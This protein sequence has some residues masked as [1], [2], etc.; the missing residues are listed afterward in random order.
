[1]IAYYDG[2]V[3]CN[4]PNIMAIGDTILIPGGTV[5]EIITKTI[6]KSKIPNELYCKTR[7]YD[8]TNECDV[9]NICEE[10][11]QSS[12][13]KTSGPNTND[14]ETNPRLMI[15]LIIASVIISEDTLKRNIERYRNN[16]L[17]Q[18]NNINIPWIDIFDDNPAASKSA[19]N[20]RPIIIEMLKKSKIAN[21]LWPAYLKQ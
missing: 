17:T 3:L 18:W 9:C 14:I 4:V 10:I 11:Y 5:Y 15:I 6:D 1:M 2:K 16:I 19:K 7:I 21:N 20:A 8:E 12:S 13:F